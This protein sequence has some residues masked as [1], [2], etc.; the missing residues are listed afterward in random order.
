MRK[1]IWAQL[2]NK[3]S[4]EIKNALD[5]DKVSGWYRD[6]TGGSAIIYRNDITGKIVS[7]HIH[8]H[9]TYGPKQLKELLKDIGWTAED[10]KRLKLI[11]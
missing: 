9:K 1:E 2:K 7:I 6:E 4:D 10:L 8:P 3:T 11:K 5:K